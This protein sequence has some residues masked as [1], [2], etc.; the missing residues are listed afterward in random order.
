MRAHRRWP[1][2]SMAQLQEGRALYV[3]KCASC[4]ALKTPNAVPA[5]RWPGE[6]AR[7]RTQHGVRLSDAEATTMERYL[8]SVASRLEEDRDGK[9]QASR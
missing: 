7:M 8:W 2:T 3:E 9:R 1:S 6:I 5:D 4:H